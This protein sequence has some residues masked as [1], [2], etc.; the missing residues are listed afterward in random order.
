MK[1]VLI[2]IV[3]VIIF[4]IYNNRMTKINDAYEK[5]M[6]TSGRANYLRDNYPLLVAYIESLPDFIVEFERTDLIRYI[7]SANRIIKKVVVQQ[8]SDMMC[9]VYVLDNAALKEWRFKKRDYTDAQ[10]AETVKSYLMYKV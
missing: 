6:N 1:W 2:V 5:A 4:V 3:I 9:V 8:F 7:N 10:M